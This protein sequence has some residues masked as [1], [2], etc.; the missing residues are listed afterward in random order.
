[1]RNNHNNERKNVG[2]YIHVPFCLSKC[3]YCDFCSVQRADEDKKER[4]VNRLCEE[5]EL[6]AKKIGEKREIPIADT[7]YFG[8][9]TPTLLS[10]SQMGGI[11]KTLDRC[12]GIDKYAE[13]TAETNP[14]SADRKKLGEIRKVGINRLSIGM[15][16]VHDSEMKALGRIHN[17]EDFK[18]TFS[19]AREVGFDNISVDLMYGIPL[20]TKESF[21]ASC[22]TL[23]DILPEHISSYALTVEEGT[24]FGR[25]RDTLILPD[26][27]SVADMYADMTAILA[28][29][30]YHKYEISNFAK[31]SKESRHNLKY[32]RCDDYL[33]FGVAAHSFYGGKRFAHSRDIDAY[34]R[35]ESIIIDL[36][37]ISDKEA[38]NEYVMLG[39]RLSGG[40]DLN[41]FRERFGKELSE[42]FPAF[43]KYTPEYVVLDRERCFFTEKG[44]LVSN[45]ILSD[46]L[47]FD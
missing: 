46:V 43:G 39:M 37:D 42:C 8:G 41:K 3:H 45:F 44:M 19:D 6:F 17:F 9:G 7:V 32:W 14:K 22:E 29:N 12:F 28:Q 18:A 15:Q 38:E 13:I 30:G 21:A 24:N 11:L 20:Q 1:M 40:M 33:G 10:A 26:E 16:S 4:Y 25:R 2:I 47:D 35:G 31:D 23:A 5:I 36:Q 27:D 34:L